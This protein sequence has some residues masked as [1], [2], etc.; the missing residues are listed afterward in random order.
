[1]QYLDAKIFLFLMFP[2]YSLASVDVRLVDAAGS[3][4]NVGLVQ[5]K[6]DTGFGS[7]CGANPAAA[8]VICRS[9]GFAYGTVSSSPCGFYG[10]SNLCGAPGSP[11]VMADLTC[12]GSEWSLEECSWSAPD[13]VCMGHAQDTIVYCS[14]T[15]ESGSISKGAIRL[16]SEDGSPSIDGKG[17]PEV[18]VDGAWSPICNSGITPGAQTVICKSMGFSGA[19]A[20][21]VSKCVG[22]GCGATAP[23]FSELAC[24]GSEHNVLECPHQAGED[25]F[26]APSESIVVSCAGDGDTQGRAVKESAPQP[27]LG[28]GVALAPVH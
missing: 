14:K 28:S 18:H 6:T 5:V 3:L 23:G 19:G 17:R 25:V 24:S 4:S 16:I 7:I 21:G 8:D 1:M 11:V 13:D 2:M 20:S 15:A 9:L 27:I 10:A 12:T 22:K 26:C